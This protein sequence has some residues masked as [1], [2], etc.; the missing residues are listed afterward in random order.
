MLIEAVLHKEVPSGK[1]PIDVEVV[2]NNVGTV[3]GVGE[4]FMYGQPLI[5]R[6]VTITGPGIKTPANLMIPIGTRL[7]D[8]VAYCD[9]IMDNTRQILFGGPMMGTAQR[10]LDV[11]RIHLG[12]ECRAGADVDPPARGAD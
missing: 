9:G 4:L 10:F 6:V 11:C 5:E 1:L 12:H 8:V 3:A 2:V 7:S